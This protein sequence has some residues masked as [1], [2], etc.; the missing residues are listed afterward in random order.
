MKRSNQTRPSRRVTRKT[1]RDQVFRGRGPHKDDL[2]LK[3]IDIGNTAQKHY[4]VD[5]MRSSGTRKLTRYLPKRKDA[6]RFIYLWDWAGEDE[7]KAYAKRAWIL[8]GHRE[9]KT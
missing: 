9:R 2:I 6:M 7:A 8:Y 1:S 5:V 3:W 4:Q